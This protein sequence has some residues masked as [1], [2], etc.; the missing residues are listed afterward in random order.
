[1]RFHLFLSSLPR[2]L[3]LLLA[4]FHSLTGLLL[5]TRI[6]QMKLGRIDVRF[7]TPFSL[8]RWLSDQKE[9]RSQPSVPT[10][11]RKPKKDQATL[12]KAL[13]YEVLAQINDASIV[14]P[15]SLVGTVLLTIRGRGVRFL[16]FHLSVSSRRTED[17]PSQVGKSELITRV[18]WLKEAIEVRGGR[19]ADFGGM[20]VAAV[21]ERSVSTFPCFTR[22]ALAHLCRNS[23]LD[24]LKPQIGVQRDLVEPT[25]Y[26]ISRFEL[27]FH[28]NAVRPLLSPWSTQS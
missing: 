19:V 15:T 22:G 3:I 1:V 21:V 12:L 6:I 10:A 26:P 27:A 16:L 24:V 13:A 8:A 17:N 5:N 23:A 20:P 28:R 18:G 9:R 4:F 7:Q 11:V 2:R 14:M 25:Y